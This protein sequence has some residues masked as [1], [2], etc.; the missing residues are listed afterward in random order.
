MT[1]QHTPLLFINATLVDGVSDT[2]LKNHQLLVEDGKISQISAGSIDAPSATV[3]DLKGKTL[4]PGLIDCHVHVIASSANLGQNAMLPDSLITARA[5]KIMQGMLNRGFTTVRDVGGADYGLKQALEEGL[6]S[7]PHLMI[8]GKALSQTGGHTDYRGRYDSRNAD[9]YAKKL[10]A[11]GRICNGVDE[12]RRAVREEI[13][14]GAEFIKVMANGGVSSPSDPIDFLSFSVSELEAIVEEASNA[15]TY[16]SAHLYTDEAIRRAVN[17]GVHS[18]EHCN[19]ITPETAALAASKGAMACPTLVTYEMLKN[20]GEQ[21]GLQPDSI[22]KID[23]VR[24]SGL[25]SLKIM[26]EAGL[27]MAY[28]SDLLG[29]MHVHQSE[30][31]VIRNRVLPAAEVIRSAT[32][33]AARL[34]RKEGEIGCLTPGAWADLIVVNGNP[35]DDLSLLTGQGKH[36]PLI[37]QQGKPVKNAGFLPVD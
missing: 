37:L 30:E 4:M 8:C 17:A 6:L 15:Q 11:L 5:G 7:G 25:D 22:A 14:A 9:F 18:L 10:G 2:A 1:T 13:K 34:L 23:D 31:F 27:P 16:V 35:L 19:L 33:I 28:G 26:F 20:E 3:V 36:I 24:L 29:D 21:Y 12:V 32:S